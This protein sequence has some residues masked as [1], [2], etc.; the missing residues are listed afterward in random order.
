M[1]NVDKK[2]CMGKCEEVC[3]E[4]CHGTSFMGIHGC[5]G[6][7]C[8]HL[9]KVILKLVIIMLIFCFGF[10]LGSITGSFRNERSEGRIQNRG[11]YGM[12]RGYNNFNIQPNTNI[13]NP[14]APATT[15]APV[16]N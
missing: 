3:H 4:N 12:M 9:V 15:V 6:G 8:H 10:K 5:H 2:E 14:T 7:K 1:E 13:Q 16:K 11:G